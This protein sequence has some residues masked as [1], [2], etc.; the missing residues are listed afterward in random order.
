[1]IGYRHCDPR[2]AFLWENDSQPPAR[3]H[4]LGEGPTHYLA[5]T[6][7]GAWAEF[8]RHEE[9]TELADLAMV[10]RAIWAIEFEPSEC[11]DVALA[12]TV[13]TGGE[14]SYDEC[15]QEA[16]TLRALG[17]QGIRAPSAALQ[18]GEAAGYHVD[19]GLKRDSAMDGV[20]YVLFGPRPDLSGWRVTG[21]ARPHATLLSAVRHL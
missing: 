21:D 3:W 13:L 7:D 11:Q 16:R 6:P 1:M 20:V 9:I 2:Y 14:D 18:S 12:Y 4:G 15:Q 5:D 17:A 10:R 19:N 8:L